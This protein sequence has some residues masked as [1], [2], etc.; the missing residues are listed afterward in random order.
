MTGAEKV[1]AIMQIIDV[2]V[3]AGRGGCRPLVAGKT[4]EATRFVK[5]AGTAADLGPRLRCNLK[6]VALM[7]GKIDQRRV[8]GK[9]KIIL[10]RIGAHR[11]TAL[12]V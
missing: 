4:D 9:A 5:L 7:A 3:T 6:I 11:F 2:A 12:T 8:A 10:D 1:L